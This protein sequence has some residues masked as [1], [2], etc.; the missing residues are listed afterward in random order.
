MCT[1]M[2]VKVIVCECESVLYVG[3]GLCYIFALPNPV[4]LNNEMCL[5]QSHVHISV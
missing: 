1:L 2:I 4:V 3:E 5:T